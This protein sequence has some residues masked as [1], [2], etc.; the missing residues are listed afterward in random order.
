MF[1]DPPDTVE[2]HAIEL[3]SSLG[4]EHLFVAKQPSDIDVD[5]YACSVITYE[6][7]FDHSNTGVGLCLLLPKAFALQKLVDIS[8]Q[9]DISVHFVFTVPSDACEFET[10]AWLFNL[11]QDRIQHVG[12][13]QNLGIT[14][15]S[16]RQEKYLVACQVEAN[17]ACCQVTWGLPSTVLQYVF[18]RD[19]V[20]KLNTVGK[21]QCLPG[22]SLIDFRRPNS[23]HR[24]SDRVDVTSLTVQI[25]GTQLD[26]IESVER[27]I[28]P[29][30]DASWSH[31]VAECQIKHFFPWS[32]KL[33]LDAFPHGVTMSVIDLKC[34]NDLE[35]KNILAQLAH[36]KIRYHFMNYRRLAIFG[37]P[38]LVINLH[39]ALLP[40]DVQLPIGPKQ[41]AFTLHIIKTEPTDN[42]IGTNS[43]CFQVKFGKIGSFQYVPAQILW[44]DIHTSIC[45][46]EHVHL[47]P[48]VKML[49]K[50][51]G[52]VNFTVRWCQVDQSQQKCLCFDIDIQ[53]E[54]ALPI[55][56]WCDNLPITIHH[57]CPAAENFRSEVSLTEFETRRDHWN[58]VITMQMV[59]KEGRVSHLSFEQDRKYAAKRY[60]DLHSSI[61][62]SMAEYT[63]IITVASQPPAW[64]FSPKVLSL[65]L[66]E[67]LHELNHCDNSFLHEVFTMGSN[68]TKVTLQQHEFSKY[69]N[70]SSWTFMYLTLGAEQSYHLKSIH[71]E[72][73]EWKIRYYDELIIR[74]FEQSSIF[75]SLPPGVTVSHV[76]DNLEHCTLREA[77]SYFVPEQPIEQQGQGA[78]HTG[79]LTDQFKHE[80]ARNQFTNGA[81]IPS[82]NTTQPTHPGPPF[83]NGGAKYCPPAKNMKKKF[84]DK[85]AGTSV[86]EPATK[87]VPMTP[88]N[89][90]IPVVVNHPRTVP[91]GTPGNDQGDVSM[92][93]DDTKLVG[94]T[95]KTEAVQQPSD[96]ANQN[97]STASGKHSPFYANHADR[98][99]HQT[100]AEGDTGENKPQHIPPESHNETIDSH[101]YDDKPEHKH[102]TEG[103]SRMDSNHKH[104]LGHP[105]SPHTAD[106]P[107]ITTD[108]TVTTE[109][110]PRMVPCPGSPVSPHTNHTTTEPN[111]V[112][113]LNLKGHTPAS[114]ATS[115]VNGKSPQVIKQ[116]DHT[117]A[118]PMP[119]TTKASPAHKQVG[120]PITPHHKSLA[121]Q[122]N[123]IKDLLNRNKA[124]CPSDEINQVDETDDEVCVILNKDETS[125]QSIDSILL[126]NDLSG[127]LV[128]VCNEIIAGWPCS[129]A[130]ADNEHMARLA[131]CYSINFSSHMCYAIT[132]LRILT[133]AP[134]SDDMFCGHIRELILCAIGCGWTWKDQT[135]TVHGRRITTAEVS[136]AV[137]SYRNPVAFPPGQNAALDT[138][139]IAVCDDLF[140]DH[141]ALF[142]ATFS[143][144]CASCGAEGQVS[145]SIFDAS[146]ITMPE[147]TTID[148]A[149]MLGERNPRLALEREEVGFAHCH[150]CINIEHLSY[151]Q[152]TAGLIFVLQILC[153]QD[154]LPMISHATD[155]L[156]QTFD[157][158]NIGSDPVFQRFRV[159]GLIVVQ[160][161]SSHHF[162][163]IEKVDHDR[164][165]IHDN[166]SGYHWIPIR[167]I[168]QPAC[169]W[170]FILRHN[171]HPSYSF[172]P[173]QYKAIAPNTT[174]PKA[175]QCKKRLKLKHGPG[176]DPKK[177]EFPGTSKKTTKK[178]A[179][180]ENLPDKNNNATTPTNA[181]TPEKSMNPEPSIK[182]KPLL[183]N[184]RGVP[185]ADNTL[186]EQTLQPNEEITHTHALS[187]HPRV[188]GDGAL[189]HHSHLPEDI[190]LPPDQGTDE[191]LHN[192][193]HLNLDG[194]AGM[195]CNPTQVD[196]PST[197]PPEAL[198][199][200]SQQEGLPT[201]SYQEETPS[202]NPDPS[203]D[204]IESSP[205][206]ATN[207]IPIVSFPDSTMNA[208][209]D[210]NCP[211]PPMIDA[212]HFNGHA[213]KEKEVSPP[214]RPRFSELHPY[215]IISLFD[216][217]GS[218]I[219]AIATAV[220]GPPC[221]VIAA[222]CDPILRQIVSEQFLFRSDGKWT[223]SCPNTYTLY[224]DDVRKILRDNCRILR[225]AFFLAGPHCRWI[226]VAG[227]PCQ[228]LTTAGPFQ[229]L[230]GLTGPCSSM[231][232]YVHSILWMLQM[233]YPIELIR[234]LV[235]N[236]GTML[237]IHRQAILKALGLNPQLPPDHFRVDPKFS[238]GIRRNRFFFRNYPDRD[239]VAHT[240]GLSLGDEE[241][242][243]L[244]Q[245]GEAIPF[246]PLLRV[247][248]VMGHDVLQLS[249]TSYQPIALIWDYTF[250]GGKKHFQHGAKMQLSDAMPSLSFANALP[251]HYLKA[252]RNFLQALC[253]RNITNYERDELVRA[254]LPIF[255]H[256]LIKAPMRILTSS[257][258]EKLA[259]L[260][261]H[262]H[263][264]Q[265]ARPL[266]TEYTIRNYCGNSFHPA[267]IQ[268]AI[269]QPERL[270]SW[271]AEPAHPSDRPN[272]QGVI[273]PK[274][275]RA[276]YHELRDKV[277]ITAATQKVKGVAEKQVGLDP[278]PDFPINAV[279]GRLTP[280]APAIH[281]SQL[282]PPRNDAKLGEIGVREDTPPKQLS[283]MAIQ[284][285]K[286]RK[287]HDILT[288]MRFFG[289]GISQVGDILSFFFGQSA[290]DPL[291]KVDSEHKEWVA[292]QLSLC[293]QSTSAM[294]QV[295][296]FALTILHQQKRFTHLVFIVD[297]EDQAQVYAFGATQ[298]QWT[299]YCVLFPKSNTFQMDTAAW[300]CLKCTTIP[301]HP[302][303]DLVAYDISP[304]PFQCTNQR[305]VWFAL[306]YQNEN[307]YL[308]SHRVL[309]TFVYQGCVPCFLSCV[310]HPAACKEHQANTPYPELT[311]TLFVNEEGQVAIAAAHDWQV[312]TSLGYQTCLVRAKVNE[313][314]FQYP[315]A[316]HELPNV[317]VIGNVD[318]A[319][320]ATLANQ[321]SETQMS[322]FVF[323]L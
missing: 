209:G 103:C 240:V 86:R 228:D 175:H 284:I 57:Q 85:Q 163:V 250:W 182:A 206:K 25:Q 23:C 98:P 40:L 81:G 31:G 59:P 19:V 277:L 244:N 151:N 140:P 186:S 189:T 272:W 112:N 185:I 218:A 150:E 148:L 282:F 239:Q 306:P 93:G 101:E 100:L 3:M 222:E 247:R 224:T 298:A 94:A 259:G 170:G 28:Q 203:D 119:H 30:I 144:H 293:V 169:I 154:Q 172:Q 80:P 126:S 205:T 29:T 107:D 268:A 1:H 275:A 254:I 68:L 156:D 276:Q 44:K 113:D 89:D 42:S 309:G 46:E 160:G 158:Q 153:T 304:M 216:G 266:L 16:S 177:Y 208:N 27:C 204:V 271:L 257:E 159:S 12:F 83:G 191:C 238:H 176:V 243:L 264:V 165:L 294:M 235:E 255:H 252:W 311:G 215:A 258:V 121:T 95:P 263:R 6:E 231:F 178:S 74:T 201:A 18:P 291:A 225:E 317:N 7:A 50:D 195:G 278:M 69:H 147:S 65:P 211:P 192:L 213:A 223:K 34:C 155:L 233:N 52:A 200:Q 214:K 36:L 274:L 322:F 63:N 66:R 261:N 24:I 221:I 71:H 179:T 313:V 305:C 92:F 237:E 75:V 120:I 227:S 202:K 193:G 116:T 187:H 135:A 122:G 173:I 149:Q 194:D 84:L 77:L 39:L 111:K 117:Q 184:H 168:R 286:Q 43:N 161:T 212:S 217:V 288:G 110:C 79:T 13:M 87:D 54:D 262:F 143:V 141:V 138:A 67:C 219:Q 234:F 133:H 196:Q 318:L 56:T 124:G 55:S 58:K 307:H 280:I 241:G 246:G 285:I 283:L 76:L 296:L 198:I 5:K 48:L 207:D 253:K 45:T 281:P 90:T 4:K 302:A 279:T 37:P 131:A 190:P 269:G 323:S 32:D 260:H 9:R 267:H 290:E 248:A 174:N 130:N 17:A 73:D 199:P 129:F 22:V 166:L 49:R 220:G 308:I 53:H 137:A 114:A 139:I 10:S 8:V 295:L 229:G 47:S 132:A 249:W 299:V 109:G 157:V 96:H 265:A 320:A 303:P 180:T 287:M 115:S 33:F 128:K 145:V 316:K 300:N 82:S 108:G 210:S 188:P 273:H 91:P 118:S 312:P 162:F 97:G 146:L 136:A 11:L 104:H 72:K 14:C 123:T 314:L 41:G 245:G 26:D 321:T 167:E 289:A 2:E 99:Y 232:Y 127:N 15:S 20:E 242:P 134:W 181:A 38:S 292:K 102:A 315:Q 60:Y 171:E 301:W 64:F 61:I 78:G 230:L 105:T 183:M 70:Y 62:D 142:F 256:P 35:L 88:G 164:V 319:F 106:R 270:R 236:A 125:F 310:E 197:S 297:W 152:A 226:V 251:P 21:L 51:F